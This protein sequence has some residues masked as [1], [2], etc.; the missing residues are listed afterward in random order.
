MRKKL[1]LTVEEDVIR[2]AKRFSARHGTS[3]SEL[4]TRFLASL[5]DGTPADTPI[6]SRLR[7]VL[8]EPASKED[9]RRHLED[10]HAR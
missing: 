2:R 8:K 6:V 4:V 7:G 9:Y 1:T 3:V 5:E 10:K